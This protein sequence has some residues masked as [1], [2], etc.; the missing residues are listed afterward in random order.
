MD[1]PNDID[2]PA[3]K[4]PTMSDDEG[5]GAFKK[6]TKTGSESPLATSPTLDEF[7]YGSSMASLKLQS[8]FGDSKR[9]R[10]RITDVPEHVEQVVDFTFN[11]A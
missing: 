1:A 2:E 6:V 10:N 8:A 7:D 11:L 3:N 9:L 5:H 4:F